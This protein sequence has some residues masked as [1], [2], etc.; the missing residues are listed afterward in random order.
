MFR[1]LLSSEFLSSLS[2]VF[3]TSVFLVTTI[4]FCLCSLQSDLIYCTEHTLKCAASRHPDASSVQFL[5]L[6]PAA[7]N[8]ET[9]ETTESVSA[10]DESAGATFY[11]LRFT[12][13]K[14]ADSFAKARDSAKNYPNSWME[15]ELRDREGETSG[16]G[17]RK[18]SEE[19]E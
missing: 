19:E 14:H 13:G 15:A 4:I 9:T 18:K 17:A 5:N 12:S 10:G 8:T 3:C 16:G 1:C 6:K 11:S 2:D 7:T